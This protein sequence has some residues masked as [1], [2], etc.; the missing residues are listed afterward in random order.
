MVLDN[1]EIHFAVS[2]H[3]EKGLACNLGDLAEVTK[4]QVLQID[5]LLVDGRGSQDGSINT[6]IEPFRGDVAGVTNL[7]DVLHLVTFSL[8]FPIAQG[9]VAAD[10]LSV[11]QLIGSGDLPVAESRP[12]GVQSLCL[13]Q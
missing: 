13:C 8:R 10:L 5:L 9:N 3:G 2:D 6:F 4:A 12:A 7:L 11:G 1:A